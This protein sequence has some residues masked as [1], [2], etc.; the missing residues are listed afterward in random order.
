MNEF[1]NIMIKPVGASC[2]LACA[3]CYYKRNTALQSSR[4]MEKEL[5]ETTIEKAFQT[6]SQ[7]VNFFWQGGE[8][9]LAGIEFYEYAIFLQKK[10]CKAK[11]FT[12]SIQTNATL[13]DKNWIDFFKKYNILLGV[14]IDLPD[15]HD[16]YRKTPEGKR[17]FSQV[18]E[19]ALLLQD[20]EIPV[21][22]L[23]CLTNTLTPKHAYEFYDIF[24]GNGFREIQC[25]PVILED[26][27]FYSPKTEDLGAFF[28]N[29]FDLYFMSSLRQEPFFIRHF[30]S[31]L[32]KIHHQPCFDCTFSKQCN[33][34]TLIE[35]NGNAYPC[36]FYTSNDYLLGNIKDSSFDLLLDTD[37]QKKFYNLK[38]NSTC[39]SCEYHFICAGA[40]PRERISSHKSIFC[41]A[42]KAL[43]QHILSFSNSFPL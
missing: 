17:T 14:S 38:I 29:L 42:Y 30:E 20:A 8:P 12:N 10:Y 39:S 23:S 31:I 36:D 21:N 24:V 43:F 2:N 33:G 15:T 25:V 34:Y 41:Q 4:T 26:T 22:I 19:N 28:C 27:T 9:L 37:A 18:W 16:L 11:L 40:C 5:L 35:K 13:I 7:R 1:Q 32:A 6:Q 3:Y